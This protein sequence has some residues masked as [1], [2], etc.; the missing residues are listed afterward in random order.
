LIL[1]VGIK[2]IAVTW[3]FES[4]KVLEKAKPDIIIENV[5]N[6]ARITK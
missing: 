4:K 3:G 5:G 6:L 1:K 2:A